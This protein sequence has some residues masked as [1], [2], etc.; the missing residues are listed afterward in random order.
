MDLIITGAIRL[1]R[2]ELSASAAAVQLAMRSD[3]GIFNSFAP[4]Q[5]AIWLESSFVEKAEAWTD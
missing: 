3:V 5:S 2:T 4:G 1:M